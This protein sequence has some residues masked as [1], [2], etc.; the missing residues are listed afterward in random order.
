MYRAMK[1]QSAVRMS[2]VL[3][4]TAAMAGLGPTQAQQQPQQQQRKAQKPIVMLPSLA[5]QGFE[6]KASLGTSLVLQKGK[7]VWICD[8]LTIK[9]SCDA[10]E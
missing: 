1:R 7:D 3:F 9:S 10:I 8:V 2:C 4:C 5:A 6:I